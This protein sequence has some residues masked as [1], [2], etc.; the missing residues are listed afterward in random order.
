METKVRRSAVGVVQVLALVLAAISAAWALAWLLGPNGFNVIPVYRLG[1]ALTWSDANGMPYEA[2]TVDGEAGDQTAAAATEIVGGLSDTA[3]GTVG[4]TFFGDESYVVLYVSSA[5]EFLWM[6][7]RALPLLGVA[8]IWWLVARILGDIRRGDGFAKKVER[9]IIAIG[10][11]VAVGSPLA[12][13]AQWKVADWLVSGSSGG[14]IATAAPLSIN[15]SVVAM[16]LVVVAIG[17]A[18]REAASMRRELA[19]LV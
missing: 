16:G 3:N 7:V 10:A 18:W 6:A 1:N 19:G 11:L 17:V 14:E 9:R 8:A 5:K 12:T 15:L 13:F 4:S 2:V